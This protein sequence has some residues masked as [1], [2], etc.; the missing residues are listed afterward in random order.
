MSLTGLYWQSAKTGA[1]PAIEAE[2]RRRAFAGVEQRSRS[3]A[4][5]RKS[6]SFP[7]LERAQNLL[8][9]Y[10]RKLEREEREQ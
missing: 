2:I 6:V 3:A 9:I 7:R 5:S 8:A 10:A 4:P 1:W